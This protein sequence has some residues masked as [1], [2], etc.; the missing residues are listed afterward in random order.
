MKL[1]SIAFTS[2]NSRTLAEEMHIPELAATIK[3]NGL[4]AP[5]VLFRNPDQDADSAGHIIIAGQR[6]FLAL[7][8]LRGVDGTLEENEYVVR[9]EGKATT[10]DLADELD[11]LEVSIIENQYREALSPMDLNRAVMKLNQKGF[12]KDKE[13]AKVLNI[14]PYRLKRIELLSADRT[15]MTPEIIEE[16]K[17]SGDDAKFTDAHWDKMRE[18]DDPDTMKDVFDHIMEKG[19][20]PR[21]LP[22]LITSVQKANNDAYGDDYDDEGGKGKDGGGMIL[23]D[24]SADGPLKYKHKGEL[25]MEIMENGDK[26]FRVKGRGED[27]SVPMDQYLE[28]LT[29][30][31][32]FKC[33]VDLKLTFLP[34]DDLSY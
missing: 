17:K 25:T 6:R 14:T 4:L 30:P 21:D 28:Y 5:L 19:L 23:E 9:N 10:D 34:K 15:K 20:P 27:D 12:M 24:D 33:K 22:S 3:K 31:E 18:I 26:V 16:L 8:I 2:N 7:Q 32:K 1:S 13:I 11:I 29:H